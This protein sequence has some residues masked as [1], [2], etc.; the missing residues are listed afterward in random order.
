VAARVASQAQHVVEAEP[1]GGLRGR[2]VERHESLPVL[3]CV[4]QELAAER[5]LPAQNSDV[6]DEIQQREPAENGGQA[7]IYDTKRKFLLQAVRHAIR[8]E[9]ANVSLEHVPADRLLSEVHHELAEL[10][11]EMGDVRVDVPE[12][13]KAVG[14][15]SLKVGRPL[16][17]DE[18]RAVAELRLLQRMIDAQ[19]QGE[20][21]S[22]FSLIQLRQGLAR[23]DAKKVRQGIED[24]LHVED[25]PVDEVSQVLAQGQARLKSIEDREA[26]TKERIERLLEAQ[27]TVLGTVPA[28][29]AWAEGEKSFVGAVFNLVGATEE[30]VQS[31]CA[32]HCHGCSYRVG[33]MSEPSRFSDDAAQSPAAFYRAHDRLAGI[34]PPRAFDPMRMPADLEGVL[35]EVGD[36]FA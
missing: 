18:V 11:E 23:G 10:N 2:Q 26:A 13:T 9:S 22:A 1:E 34:I 19:R 16:E 7:G 31:C 17:A 32:T 29:Q 27:R 8:L 5:C 30:K 3:F 24:S 20:T 36:R 6:W 4:E 33:R 14:N 25:V 21:V 15:V 28:I 35:S 12:L